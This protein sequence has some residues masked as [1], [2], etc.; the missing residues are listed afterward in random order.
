MADNNKI[1]NT[2]E[3]EFAVFCIENTA[4]ELGI[5]ADRLYKALT[6]K[7]DILYSYIIPCYEPLHTQGKDYIIDDIISVI[8]EKGVEV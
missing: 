1:K 3:L 7:S 2:D 8:R 6:E 4:V 5:T